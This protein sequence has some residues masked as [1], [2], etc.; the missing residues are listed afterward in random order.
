MPPCHYETLG[1]APTASP[2]DVRSAYRALAQRWH[3]DRADGDAVRF[4]RISEAY[5]ILSNN[6]D[7]ARYDATLRVTANTSRG[8]NPYTSAY[9]GFNSASAHYR[10]HYQFHDA[11]DGIHGSLRYSTSWG[12]TARVLLI[13]GV[14]CAVLMLLFLMPEDKVPPPPIPPVAAARTA[15]AQASFDRRRASPAAAARDAP[16]IERRHTS[17]A[18][19]AGA[20]EVPQPRALKRGEYFTPWELVPSVDRGLD[21]VVV[22][23]GAARRAARASDTGGASV[24]MEAGGPSVAME[25]SA[26]LP[27]PSTAG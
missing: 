23:L 18:V 15:S 22:D 8:Y 10:N 27:S 9:S 19:P 17:S 21:E 20:R 4:K 7:R 2:E 1:V 3:P 16:P 26:A 12:A 6:A 13:S 24:A 25:A 5:A 14:G 11:G